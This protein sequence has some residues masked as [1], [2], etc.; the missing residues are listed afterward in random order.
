MA[1]AALRGILVV[2][3]VI[4]GV[5]VMLKAFPESSAPAAPAAATSPTSQPATGLP[6]TVLPPTNT[7]TAGQSPAPNQAPVVKGVKIQILNG[8]DTS[9]LAADM[10]KTLEKAGYK[11][12]AVGNAQRTYEATTIFFRPDSQAQA[13]QVAQSYFPEAKL[14]PVNNNNQPQIQVTIVLG[15]D[16]ADKQ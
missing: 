8:T 6:E 13:Q 7:P 10:A 12:L 9:G 11:V 1:T 15:Q 14:E 5:V 4:L 16:F 2:G 3:A